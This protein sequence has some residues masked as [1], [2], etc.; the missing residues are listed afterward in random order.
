MS[1]YIALYYPYVGIS[2]SSWVKL[3]ALY[4]DK[5][6]R[7]RPSG[8]DLGNS[9]TVQELAE[10]LDFVVDFEPLRNDIS[11]VSRFFVDMI[12][13]H[14][15]IITQKYGAQKNEHTGTEIFLIPESILIPARIMTEEL[16]NSLLASKLARRVYP[17]K[18]V[19]HLQLNIEDVVL[20]IHS[21]I[22]FLY[23]GILAEH[24]SSERR[25]HLVT[26]KLFN[27]LVVNNYSIERLA[28]TIFSSDDHQ[29]YLIDSSLAVDELELRM[30]TIA[31]QSVL[32]KDI[33]NIP[34]KQIVKLRQQHRDEM[35][36]FQKYIHDFATDMENL[37]DI[38]DIRAIQTHLE[39]EYEKRL[40]PQLDDLRKCLKSLG[41]D[42]VMSALNI[43][44]ALPPILASASS[45]LHLPS[46]N[47]LIVGAGAIAFSTFPVI[48]KKQSELSKILHSSPAAYLLYAQEGL[49][50]ATAVTHV[51]RQARKI[52][53]RV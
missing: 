33:A 22:F 45:L 36:V 32:P 6:G 3:A 21:D 29:S 1:D 11:Y 40:K 26:D 41:I 52:L 46:F 49:E 4:W 19:R 24:M 13:K 35:T 23:M 48:Q 5:L 2:D 47:P 37:Q 17:E 8:Y 15:D 16:S 34:T 25:L 30:A 7:V 50:P 27:H 18:L 9:D 12:E 28:Q 20:E 42:T 14:K 31:L 43:R 39:V 53:F 51:V 44:V 10:E 38:Q